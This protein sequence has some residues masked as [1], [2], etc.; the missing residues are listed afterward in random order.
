M[1]SIVRY[2]FSAAK[3]SK[4]YCSYYQSPNVY[5]TLGE[6]KLM[7]RAERNEEYRKT[8]KI[9]KITVEEVEG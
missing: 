5:K 7:A 3:N 8:L 9:Y 2:D 4:D 1:K 6:A